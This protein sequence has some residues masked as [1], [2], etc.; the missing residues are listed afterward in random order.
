MGREPRYIDNPGTRDD[1]DNRRRDREWDRNDDPRYSDERGANRWHDEWSPNNSPNPNYRSGS[2]MTADYGEAWDY[3]RHQSGQSDPGRDDQRGRS[4][5]RDGQR[6]GQRFGQQDDPNRPWSGQNSAPPDGRSISS[7]TSGY[8]PNRGS[9]A[10]DFGAGD[11]WGGVESSRGRWMDGSGSRSDWRSGRVGERSDSVDTTS[12]DNGRYLQDGMSQG[13]MY[14]GRRDGA[15]RGEH[16]GKGPKGYQ[17]SDERVKETVSERLEAHPDLDAS[18]I[19]VEVKSGVVTL[20]GTVQDRQA[21]RMAEDAS[22]GLPG[23]KDVLNQLQVSKQANGMSQQGNRM[24][25]DQNGKDQNS[26]GQ[27]NTAQNSDR[28]KSGS[29]RG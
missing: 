10:P 2:R 26:Q 18:D 3:G 6:D 8:G 12:W 19:E 25:Q 15:S 28:Q 22:E 27:S 24:S 4:R 16:F 9:F 20:S 11:M 21:K 13:G 7:D 29:G 1:R 14:P 17:R 23:V 5:Y